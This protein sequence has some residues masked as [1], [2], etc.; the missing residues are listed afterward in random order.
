MLDDAKNAIGSLI[1][2]DAAD[3][4]TV[5]AFIEGDVY[6]RHGLWQGVDIRPFSW[7]IGAPTA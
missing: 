2:I 5:R 4:A 1:I 6:R 7:T 3:I